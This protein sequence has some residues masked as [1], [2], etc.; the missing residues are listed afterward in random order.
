MLNREQQF[1]NKIWRES[2][3]TEFGDE[4]HN[5]GYTDILVQDSPFGKQYFEWMASQQKKKIKINGDK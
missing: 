2:E 3:F 5:N 1:E 4:R